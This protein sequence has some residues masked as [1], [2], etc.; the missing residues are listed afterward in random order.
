MMQGQKI[1]YGLKTQFLS[2]KWWLKS[3]LELLI[4]QSRGIFWFCEETK[5]GKRRCC[6]TEATPYL[7]LGLRS[8]HAG[9]WW[10]RSVWL[11]GVNWGG[12]DLSH[13]MDR[14]LGICVF[15]VSLMRVWDIER[16]ES[17]GLLYNEGGLWSTTQGWR[18]LEGGHWTMREE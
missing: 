12:K 18:T 2:I 9:L 10:G 17:T 8:G 1:I 11:S 16:R 15:L 7:C 5:K 3:L 14:N 4:E 13:V 6:K